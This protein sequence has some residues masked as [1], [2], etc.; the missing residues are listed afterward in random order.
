[1]TDVHRVERAANTRRASLVSAVRSTHLE[2]PI[3][4]VPSFAPSAA[5]RVRSGSDE[6][7]LEVRAA[8]G[9]PSRS[10]AS[11][12]AISFDAE[13]RTFALTCQ[14][15]APPANAIRRSRGRRGRRLAGGSGRRSGGPV[16][17]PG[18][19]GDIA[20]LEIPRS[21][22]ARA[23]RGAASRA[24]GRRSCSVRRAAPVLESRLGSSSYRSWHVASG[25]GCAASTTCTSARRSTCRRNSSPRPSRG[26]PLDEP[27]MSATTIATS[28]RATP[29]FG[30]RVVNGSRRSSGERWSD[31]ASTS[32]T[33]VRQPASPHREQLHS[34]SI[35][36][37]R[38]CRR[39][40]RCAAPSGARAKRALPFPPVLAARD[41]ELFAGAGGRPPFGRS[42]DR[43]PGSR[44]GPGAS[45]RCGPTTAVRPLPAALELPRSP[46]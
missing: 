31:A 5:A 26:S 13:R 29:R 9:R 46:S 33:R 11:A 21:A 44:R 15:R 25:S 20:T 18:G 38:L 41:D 2:V 19:R 43:S 12:D 4:P 1:M 37:R 17:C 35:S 6:L 30:T 27:G 3:A 32:T 34:R 16:A 40:R 23:I 28:R 24:S 45:I 36:L 39:P 8:S 42:R 22:R 10:R 14:S 7:P